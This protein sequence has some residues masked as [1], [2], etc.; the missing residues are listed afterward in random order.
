M[1]TF[2]SLILC[3]LVFYGLGRTERDRHGIYMMDE[4]DEYI[5]KL[6]A[7]N[8]LLRDQIKN[9]GGSK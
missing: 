4:K 3:A 1:T 2:F 7:Y 9:N 8:K 5:K 6:N